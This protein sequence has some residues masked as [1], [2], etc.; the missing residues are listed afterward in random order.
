MPGVRHV[1]H[2][3]VIRCK[4][5]TKLQK[6]LSERGVETSIHYPIPIHLQGAYRYL[7][8]GPG[9]FPVA[10][11]TAQQVL[12]LPIYPELTDAKVRQ[13]AALIRDWRE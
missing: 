3:Y 5:R 4:D 12:S 8:L 11:R 13:V 2:L 6:H 7:D 10:E 1:Y 9:S